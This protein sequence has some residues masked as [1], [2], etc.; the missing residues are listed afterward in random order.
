MSQESFS[1]GAGMD[2]SD[3]SSLELELELESAA[4]GIDGVDSS[5]DSS[6]EL[7]LGS[8]PGLF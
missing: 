6:L 5:D 2:G 4:A 3:D 1:C 7:E 8:I